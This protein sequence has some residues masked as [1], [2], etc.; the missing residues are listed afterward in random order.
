[1]SEVVLHDGVTSIAPAAFAG[2]VGLKRLDLPSSLQTVGG[3]DGCTGLIELT[4]PSKTS[5][6]DR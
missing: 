4:I 1:L 2:C 5:Q 3:F 6:S